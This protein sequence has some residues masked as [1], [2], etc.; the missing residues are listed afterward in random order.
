MSLLDKPNDCYVWFW[1]AACWRAGFHHSRGLRL[2][3]QRLSY[4][5]G[6]QDRAMATAEALLP[7]SKADGERAGDGTAPTAATAGGKKAGFGA[8]DI[9]WLG[10]ACLICNSACG[11]G[12]VQLPGLM[13][14]AGWV[15]PTLLFVVAAVWTVQASL[16]LT[17][18]MASMPGNA[19]FQQRWEYG[20]LAKALLP[21]WAYWLA[22]GA[23]VSSFVAQNISN[24]IV[25]AQVG[26]CGGGRPESFA[27]MRLSAGSLE[28]LGVV[29]LGR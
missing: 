10:G 24:I 3:M 27:L 7:R 28:P 23:I 16:Y 21:R 9:S 14:S 20:A 13:Q 29:L 26:A 4:L 17:R 25:S 22:L 8:H 6:V 1:D 11:S 19:S 5:L 18:A 2:H 12:M 15:V